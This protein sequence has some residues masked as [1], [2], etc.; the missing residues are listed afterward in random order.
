[1]NLDSAGGVGSTF[2]TPVTVMDAQ[3][4]SHV[5]TFDFTNTAANTWTY[6][7]TIPAADL[8]GTGAPVSVG[9]GTLKFNGA[10]VLT[11]PAAD[12]TD[13]RS[14]DSPM[15]RRISPSTGISTTRAAIRS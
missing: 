2:S 9:T 7:I 6:T 10:G 13:S 5:L 15:A 12:V 11:T 14:P 3:G 4:N 8:G 1:M